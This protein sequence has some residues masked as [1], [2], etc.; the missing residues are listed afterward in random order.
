MYLSGKMEEILIYSQMCFISDKDN[1]YLE[2]LVVGETIIILIFYYFL[3]YMINER[4]LGIYCIETPVLDVTAD[5][6]II[7]KW[8]G[9][10]S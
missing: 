5:A 6:L 2:E 4:Q 7:P 1:W 10:E 3:F 9:K 8:R